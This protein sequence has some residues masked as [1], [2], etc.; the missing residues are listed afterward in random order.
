ML[1]TIQKLRG[2]SLGELLTRSRQEVSKSLELLGL[3]SF[4]N[5]QSVELD[6]FD[7]RRKIFAPWLSD[8]GEFVS[9]VESRL[10]NE[11]HR[12]LRNADR[13]RR[14]RFD[15]LG[16]DALDFGGPIPDWHRDPVSG[17]QSPRIHWSRINEIDAAKTGDKKVIWE[18]NRHQYFET[19]GQAYL[20]SGDEAFAE[21]FT[22]HLEDWIEQNPPKVGVNWL[23]SL[24]LALRSISWIRAYFYFEPSPLFTPKLRQ[25]MF[26]FLSLQ[27]R[28]I[29]TYLSTYFA[30]NTHITGE[31]LGLYYIGTF[32]NG[33]QMSTRWKETGYRILMAWLCKHIRPDG[34]YCEQA[35]H[36]ARYTA[37]FYSD[38][39]LLREREGL[40]I[41]DE[42][43]SKLALLLSFLKAITRPD[44]TL[45]L[46]GDDDGGKY[47]SLEA[48]PIDDIRR[49]LL[50]GAFLFDRG[51]LKYQIENSDNELIWIAGPGSAMALAILEAE[52]PRGNTR[53]FQNG[54]FYTYRSSWQPNA[55][56]IVIMCGP[57]GFMN[58]G[59][60]HADA[61]SFVA[62][63]AGKP[64]FVD[65]G[66]FVYTSDLEARDRYRSSTA[67]NCLTVNGCSSSRTAG[68][69]SWKSQA[70]ARL[71]EWQ[72]HDSGFRFCGS[73]DGFDVLDVKYERSIEIVTRGLLKIVD[74]VS[75]ET[76]HSYEINLILA[77]GIVVTFDDDVVKLSGNDLDEHDVQMNTKTIEGPSDSIGEWQLQ[78]IQVSPVYGKE[79]SSKKL[80]FSL[81]GRGT[82]V[83]ET[84][85]TWKI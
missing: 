54:G 65:S 20:L 49:L 60:A 16:F 41:D 38:L 51:D 61:L 85:V 13:I 21:T 57:H 73:H 52:E 3:V 64:V 48:R 71:I 46:F 8:R 25:R 24:E 39:I 43:K 69:F 29:E 32:L 4:E 15:L 1:G 56:H 31:G 14:G 74:R 58:G 44:D 72:E 83:F 59:H 53:A 9:I 55:D 36:Y 34:S 10:P 2:R 11:R 17:K 28:H 82:I 47:F 26:R 77:T 70:N 7:D 42:L 35:S 27:A 22:G 66:T 75:S 33:G 50:L 40:P 5:Y 63:L 79:V 37:D 45:P 30:P 78:D 84:T 12:I 80:V 76:R 23:S 62:S 81:T 68:P 6:P 67:H 18:L 19:L